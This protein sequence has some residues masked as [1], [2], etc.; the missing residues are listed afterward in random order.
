MSHTLIPLA[1]RIPLDADQMT[2]RVLTRLGYTIDARGAGT[3]IV[4]GSSEEGGQPV[5]GLTEISELVRAL[6]CLGDPDSAGLHQHP[7]TAAAARLDQV[8]YERAT[9]LVAA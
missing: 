5:G 8:L 2:R 1:L 7:D 9:R 6:G 3:E 4:F